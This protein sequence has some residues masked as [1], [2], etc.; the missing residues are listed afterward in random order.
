MEAL[1]PPRERLSTV[2]EILANG[3]DVDQS[4]SHKAAHTSARDLPDL[5]LSLLLLQ[6][7]LLASTLPLSILHSLHSRLRH[8][9][10]TTLL[11]SPTH[12][13][14]STPTR[15]N[16]FSSS[17]WHHLNHHSRNTNDSSSSSST[18]NGTPRPR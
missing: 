5:D 12:S 10:L 18:N 11:L 4:I 8:T 3:V 17:L 13:T 14:L 7:D 2:Q 15:S 6:V 1:C 16:L 9:P